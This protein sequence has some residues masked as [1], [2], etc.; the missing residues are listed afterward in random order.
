MFYV[1]ENELR[2]AYN[3]EH[4]SSYTLP[5]DAKLTP[6]ARQF[7]I[8]FHI[9]FNEGYGA[10][11]GTAGTA[12]TDPALAAAR[13]EN[14]LASFYDDIVVL[15]ARLR[16]LGRNALGIENDIAHVCDALGTLWQNHTDL[17]GLLSEC[18]TAGEVPS[19]PVLPPLSA[20]VHPLYYEMALLDA[21]LARTQRFWAQAAGEMTAEG[22]AS[23]DAWAQSVTRCRACLATCLEKVAGEA[24]HG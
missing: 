19:A 5:E 11:S 16:M 10:A 4:F 20:A 17:G 24:R 23:V 14:A 12:V 7:L 1:T 21:E 13:A 8:D 6:S 2:G 9:D 3:R 18:E 22:H 15:G